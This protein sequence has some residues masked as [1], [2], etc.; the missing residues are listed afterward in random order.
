MH[1]V[2]MPLP[3]PTPGIIR[4]IV[5][6]TRPE[7][8]HPLPAMLVTHMSIPRLED[9]LPPHENIA[10]ILRPLFGGAI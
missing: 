8:T 4:P 1:R 2:I 6:S 9:L 7:A 3:L 10:I 5:K